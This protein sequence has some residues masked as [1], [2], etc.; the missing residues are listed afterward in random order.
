LSNLAKRLF[1][2]RRENLLSPWDLCQIRR[3]RH[4]GR[5][6]PRGARSVVRRADRQAVRQAHG[7]E[8][9][10]R[11]I[12]RK[13][14][15]IGFF[16]DSGSRPALRDLAGMT[17]CDTVYCLVTHKS[18]ESLQLTKQVIRAWAACNNLLALLPSPNWLMSLKPLRPSSK[19]PWF[20][21]SSSVRI[22]RAIPSCWP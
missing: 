17:N 22:S 4:S 16:L 21:S 6:P 7:P 18:L 9:G 8:Q 13:F 12:Q 2:Q 5:A 10:R 3:T 14:N 1:I 11:G 15:R 19:T 20:P